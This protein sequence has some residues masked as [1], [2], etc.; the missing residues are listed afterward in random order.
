MEEEDG[1][2]TMKHLKLKPEQWLLLIR[3]FTLAQANADYKNAAI[4]IKVSNDTV[5]NMRS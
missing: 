4:K 5:I 1:L 2:K 3:I